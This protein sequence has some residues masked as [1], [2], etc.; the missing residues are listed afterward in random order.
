MELST[1]KVLVFQ[2]YHSLNLLIKYILMESGYKKIYTIDNAEAIV[3]TYNHIKP[4]VFL[5][6][7][8][9]FHQIDSLIELLSK[10]ERDELMSKFICI[11]SD[12]NIQMK[13][14]TK[15]LGVKYH[16]EKPFN[17]IDEVKN[18]VN[19]I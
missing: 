12:D 9:L 15:K 4:D 3:K 14:Y 16:I 18:I 8:D 7:I 6:E 17:K 1:K 5:C 11:V 13:K 2:E 10:A 19:C